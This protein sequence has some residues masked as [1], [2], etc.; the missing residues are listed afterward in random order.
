MGIR[1]D[2][3]RERISVPGHMH[4]HTHAILKGGIPVITYIRVFDMIG[5]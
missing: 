5:P 2:Y 1:R 3:V 4:T